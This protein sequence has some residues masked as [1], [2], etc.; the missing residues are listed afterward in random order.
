MERKPVIRESKDSE[1]RIIKKPIAT[2][3]KGIPKPG[4][5]KLENND[6]TPEK[7]VVMISCIVSM[8][9]PPLKEHGQK[10]FLAVKTGAGS[11][12]GILGYPRQERHRRE[13]EKGL[14]SQ[15]VIK[16]RTAEIMESTAD[17]SLTNT[18]RKSRA[19]RAKSGR[20][21]INGIHSIDAINTPNIRHLTK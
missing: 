14:Y 7:N 15:P 10:F 11:A 1:K 17:T 12:W 19:T 9:K 2:F 6:H 20:R 3:A 18:M 8:G 4:T 21:R 5:V 16:L 13:P